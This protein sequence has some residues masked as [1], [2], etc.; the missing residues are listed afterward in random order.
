MRSDERKVVWRRALKFLLALYS[1]VESRRV[2]R[3]LVEWDGANAVM[4]G[5]RKVR[6][7]PRRAA[8]VIM[9]TVLGISTDLLSFGLCCAVIDATP[10]ARFA[11]LRGVVVV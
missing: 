11:R 8:L 7:K 5:E 1:G 9:V 3:R 2:L 10:A 6:R 4:A